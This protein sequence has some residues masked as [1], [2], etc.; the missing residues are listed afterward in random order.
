VIQSRAMIDT[1]TEY[2]K[3]D[4]AAITGVNERTIHRAIQAGQLSARKIPLPGGGE[5]VLIS[6]EEL[7]RWI[8]SRGEPKHAPAVTRQGDSAAPDSNALVS[9][10][11]LTA[12]VAQLAQNQQGIA[13]ILERMGAR[14]LPAPSDS[15]T[16]DMRPAVI[17]PVESKPLITLDEARALTGLS[18]NHLLDAIHAK[19]L[20]AKIIGRGWR[21]KRADLD[22]YLKKL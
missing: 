1:S 9:T 22:A 11:G 8:D 2:G 6:G 17:V 7:Q 5:K 12:A 19:K 13:A 4:A 18:R 15:A 10:S 16:P 14:L 3:R 20:R 21:I